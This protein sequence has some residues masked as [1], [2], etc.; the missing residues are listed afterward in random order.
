MLKYGENEYGI[1]SSWTN[2]FDSSYLDYFFKNIQYQNSTTGDYPRNYVENTLKIGRGRG[3]EKRESDRWYNTDG[4]GERVEEKR[5]KRRR[6]E[7]TEQRLFT[8]AAGWCM[9]R[10]WT[11]S[12]PFIRPPLAETRDNLASDQRLSTALSKG[13]SLHDPS[14][15][16]AWISSHTRWKRGAP[17][18]DRVTENP[19]IVPLPAFFA[20]ST[21]LACDAIIKQR[22]I[23]SSSPTPRPEWKNYPFRAE[24]ERKIENR[25]ETYEVIFQ[26]FSKI[27]AALLVR[28]SVPGRTIAVY[29][30]PTGIYMN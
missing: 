24:K 6:G 14:M 17:G 11:L 5:G 2:P 3:R 30:A 22:F 15:G 12:V 13:P 4:R 19:N 29:N 20:D 1:S 28:T 8:Q 18:A 16:L 27:I 26:K 10:C 23:L 25:V 7:K 21:D 9:V